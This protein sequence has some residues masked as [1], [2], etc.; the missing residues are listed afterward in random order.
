M[1]PV[2]RRQPVTGPSDQRNVRLPYD[3][4]IMM[5]EHKEGRHAAGPCRIA[6]NSEEAHILMRRARGLCGRAY[7]RFTP[8]N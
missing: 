5:D 8:A 7:V 3:P 1:C 6:G 4:S 2:V